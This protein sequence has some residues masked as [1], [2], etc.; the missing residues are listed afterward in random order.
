[1]LVLARKVNESIRIGDKIVVKVL[2]IQ[3]GQVKLGIEAPKNVEI[4]RWEIYE[5]IVKS[6]QEAVAAPKQRAEEIAK[7][8]QPQTSKENKKSNSGLSKIQN[9]CSE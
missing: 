2:S 7:K 5:Q 3:E 9:T 8:L 6:N 4:L 1:M